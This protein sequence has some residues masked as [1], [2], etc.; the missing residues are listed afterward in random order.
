MVRH[1]EGVCK[2]G[3]AAIECRNCI[4]HRRKVA[5]QDEQHEQHAANEAEVGTLMDYGL[6]RF[7][8]RCYPKQEGQCGRHRKV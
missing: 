5:R 8:Y 6:S 1:V 2:R 3:Y 7:V 4:Q